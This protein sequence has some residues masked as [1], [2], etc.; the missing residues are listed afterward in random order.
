[1][2]SMDSGMVSADSG[3]GEHPSE[4]ED[5]DKLETPGLRAGTAGRERPRDTGRGRHSRGAEAAEGDA[6]PNLAE[7]PGGESRGLP[8]QPVLRALPPIS[9]VAHDPAGHKRKR[10]CF[11]LLGRFRAEVGFRFSGR[12]WLRTSVLYI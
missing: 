12:P 8:V 6:E 10:S 3:Q 4:L 11:K 7:V 2:V 9:E 1:M 5:D